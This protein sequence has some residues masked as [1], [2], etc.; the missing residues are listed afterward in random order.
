M[1]YTFHNGRDRPSDRAFGEGSHRALRA[2]ALLMPRIMLRHLLAAT[3]LL[4]LASPAQAATINLLL[5]VEMFEPNAGQPR[6]LRF[7]FSFFESASN[8][9]PGEFRPFSIFP[10]LPGV[11]QYDVSLNAANLDDIYFIAAGEYTSFGPGL[12][13]PP[14]GFPSYYIAQ[15]LTGPVNGSLVLGF[16]PPWISLANLGAGFSSDFVEINGPGTRGRIGT[17]AIT[18]AVENPVPVP[19]PASM[20]LLGCGLAALAAKK[21][22]QSKA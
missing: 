9:W 15:P 22:R 14:F 16:G 8:G 2:L 7:G 5:T 11:S 6:E 20:L 18:P 4:L 10:A 13:P 1:I 12:P 21:Y 19:E 17:W 3:L